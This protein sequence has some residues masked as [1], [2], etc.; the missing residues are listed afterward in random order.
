MHFP[1]TCRAVLSQA[2][3]GHHY[4]EGHGYEV[5]IDTPALDNC[6]DSHLADTLDRLKKKG[7]CFT[8]HAPFF[9][10]SPGAVDRKVRDVT[11]ERFLQ[12]ARLANATRPRNIVFHTGYLPDIYGQGKYHRH[13]LESAAE[14]FLEI[15]EQLDASITLSLENIFERE[16]SPLLRLAETINHPR[17]GFCLDIGHAYIFSPLASQAWVE[18]F[19]TKLLELHVHDNHG[20][21]DEHLPCG[22]GQ[23]DFGALF[24]HLATL[25]QRPIIT[26]ENGSEHDFQQGLA[27]L[28]TVSGATFS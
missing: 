1:V 18:A 10:L 9:D 19:G 28:R 22:A 17:V 16:P 5:F 3:G 27:H 7:D 24:Q 13:W 23:V 4:P 6:S 14:L 15:I 21:V 20:A 26:L 25:P 2:I 12:T 11:R 8:F